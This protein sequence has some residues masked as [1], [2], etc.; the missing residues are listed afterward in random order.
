VFL[1]AL[2]AVQIFY[3]EANVVPTVASN[4][5]SKRRRLST[6]SVLRSCGGSEILADQ[7]FDE[8]RGKQRDQKRRGELGRRVREG[9]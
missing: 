3:L 9:R 8:E 2:H 1:E 5:F 7:K 6:I 4:G